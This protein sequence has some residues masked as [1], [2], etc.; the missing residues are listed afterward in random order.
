MRHRVVGSL[1]A[2]CLVAAHPLAQSQAPKPTFEVASVKPSEPSQSV[3][4]QPP[5]CYT[6]FYQTFPGRFRATKMSL[7]E[8]VGIAYE[9]PTN[10]I[11][12]PEWT[13]SERFDVMATHDSAASGRAALKAMLQHLLQDRSFLQVHREPRPM[14]VYVLK[15]ARDDGKLGPQLVSIT[16]CTERPSFLPSNVGCGTMKVPAATSRVAR[17][18]WEDLALHQHFAMSVDRPVI[19]ETGLTGWFAL[20]LDW[21]N[22]LTGATP[23]NE[24][25]ADVDRPSLFT[26]LRV[27]LGL[28]LEADKRPIEVLVIDRVERPTPD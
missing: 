24:P 17:A 16:D 12:G 18:K 3:W 19:D 15:R 4:C 5:T 21:S 20:R 27:Q 7:L 23:L 6:G 2:A 25:T 26:A 14:P 10:L 1:L 13:K 8:L 28:K 22:D 9:M 11:V